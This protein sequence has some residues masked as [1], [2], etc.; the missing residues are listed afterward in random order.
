MDLKRCSYPQNNL[1]IKIISTN[2]ACF[3]IAV[4]CP[5]NGTT[6]CCRILGT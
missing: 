6:T 3:A 2:I 5:T 4:I 1:I